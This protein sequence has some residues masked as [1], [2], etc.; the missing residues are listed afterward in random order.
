VRRCI[1][2]G[3]LQTAA[4]IRLG[5]GSHR[6]SSSLPEG[7]RF[8]RLAP[9]KTECAPLQE[10]R[11]MSRASSPLLFGLAPRGVF[12]ALAIASE[13]VGS[14]PTFSPLPTARALRDVSQVLPARCHRAALRRRFNFLWHYPWLRFVAKPPGVTRRVALSRVLANKSW[15]CLRTVSGLSSR[16][17]ALR[18]SSQ[19]LPGPPAMFSIP[20]ECDLESLC[21]QKRKCFQMRQ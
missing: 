4:I 21:A 16:C 13:A 10:R 8:T 12:R 1:A 6:D 2:H 15:P 18:P 20:C 9:R 5:P 3:A 7:F 19:R 11:S 17:C 14:Y